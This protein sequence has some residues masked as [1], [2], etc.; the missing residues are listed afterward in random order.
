MF[1]CFRDG[2][3][4]CRQAGVQWC[5][6]S[7]LQPRPPGFKRFFRLSLL[8]S[9]DHRRVLPRPAHFCIFSRDGVSPWP[10]WSRFLDLVIRPPQPRP[11]KTESCSVTRL[12]CGGTI[13]AHCNLCLPGSSNSTASTSQVA[14]TTGMHHHAQ[15]IFVF[16]QTLQTVLIHIANTRT[17]TRVLPVLSLSPRLECNDVISSHCKLHLLGSSDSPASTSPVAEITGIRQHLLGKQ[18]V[19]CSGVIPRLSQLLPSITEGQARMFSYHPL[20]LILF[21]AFH[22]H[23]IDLSVI[24]NQVIVF[25]CDALEPGLMLL[26][27]L[28]QLCLF[29][30]G[31]VQIKPQCLSHTREEGFHHVG[32]AGLELLT[33]GNLPTSA[34][35]SAGIIGVSDCTQAPVYCF[36][37][38]NTKPVTCGKAVGSGVTTNKKFV[39]LTDLKRKGCVTPWG[40]MGKC[41]GK[42]KAS[43][44]NCS[45]GQAQRLT[46][47]IPALWE[48]EAGRLLEVRS[49]RLLPV[50][51][52][53]TSSLLK[54]HKLARVSLSLPRLECNGAISAHCNFHL[55]GSI[56][57]G[58]HHIG[59]AGLEP[60]TSS[61]PPASASQSAEITG[62]SHHGWPVMAIHKESW[63]D[64]YRT[65]LGR[66]M[67]NE[68]EMH[69]QSLALWP[70]LEC[71]GAISAHC[72]LCLQG[73]SDSPVSAS[74]QD[75]ITGAHHNT[76]LIF[77]FLV[78]TGF[79]H[80]AM[81]NGMILVYCNLCL[82]G[83]S[84]SPASASGV[85]GI[86]GMSHHARLIFVFLV[87]MGFH[88]VGQ[89]GLEP[90]TSGDLPTSAS[91][92]A[93]ITGASHCTWPGHELSTSGD[94][95]ASA[96]QS[97]GIIGVSYCAWLKS[98]YLK[99]KNVSALT[100]L[101]LQALLDFQNKNILKGQAQWL[102]PVILALWEAK[103]GGSRGQEIGTNPG[104]HG[105][106]P[107]LLKPRLEC[108]DEIM[109]HSSLDLLGSNNPLT[110]ATQNAEITGIS[111]CAQQMQQ[112]RRGREVKPVLG[113]G[114]LEVVG[115][116]RVPVGQ[117]LPEK[118]VEV[119]SKVFG[120][121]EV[122]GYMD[123]FFS[124][125]PKTIVSSFCLCI[126]MES[127]FVAQVKVCTVVPSW[128]TATSASR[129]KAILLPQPPE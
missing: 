46:P 119:I 108:S 81:C 105:E 51:H 78:E 97:V 40:H 70:R 123:K 28:L 53:E 104:Q 112:R 42:V 129:V 25:L 76:W 107:S 60:L 30:T 77:A 91:Q 126:L 120:E 71:S 47:I 99:T 49:S 79:C 83:S 87:G 100:R 19:I 16:Q 109:A 50:Q 117:T 75:R 35:Q 124:G 6:L 58:F 56:E 8:S 95:P 118:Q 65:K 34:S 37:S 90:L 38:H 23:L 88:H 59:Q 121:Q 20:V 85:A 5:N 2:V 110:S 125:S 36:F 57:R 52:G 32:Q 44:E 68:E 111:H 14:E 128:L 84:N 116:F 69:R 11:P 67:N 33:S 48:A 9:W 86:T 17:D 15:R 62:V 1:V 7:S 113:R 102:T 3:L 64:I 10:G 18:L 13:L 89:A 122:F 39:M 12:E 74:R 41:Q 43:Y 21:I 24:R 103:A 106:T 80:S 98:H 101:I 66:K 82:P 115:E 54:T 27:L 96:S 61:D 26:F 63:D 94:L 55:P 45:T 29:H 127:C 92:S 114:V 22:V 31:S 72:K 93:G 4:L 73:S